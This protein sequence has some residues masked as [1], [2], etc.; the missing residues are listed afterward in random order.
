[1]VEGTITAMASVEFPALALLPPVSVRVHCIA[2]VAVIEGALKLEVNPL[3]SP[4]TRLMIAAG[5]AAAIGLLI[6]PGGPVPAASVRSACFAALFVAPVVSVM[7][8][9]G[10]A[11]R[12]TTVDESDCTD[13]AE[14]ELVNCTPG[15]VT[16]W[17]EIGLL[18]V[19]LS[20]LAVTVREE[21]PVAAAAVA[22][23]VKVGAL[24]PFVKVTGLALH[25][26]VTPVANP[27]TLSV[28]GP[29][30][31]PFP[32]SATVSLTLAP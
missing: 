6:R 13:T 22:V 16:T 32:A 26:A 21:E 4:E 28:I 1:M 29:L 3:G 23:R 31:V 19:R 30:K 24:A 15:G 27:V 8:P 12:V 7:P 2:P 17:R 25:V 5:L 20:P 18:T 11:V 10:V 14:A 9:T